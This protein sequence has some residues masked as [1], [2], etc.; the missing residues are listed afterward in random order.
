MRHQIICP[1][2]CSAGHADRIRK[3]SQRQTGITS[4]IAL[5]AKLPRNEQVF[6]CLHCSAVWFNSFDEMHHR[7]ITVVLGEYGGPNSANAFLPEAWLQKA[8]MNLT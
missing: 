3:L 7:D 6:T 8:I 5:A 2:K 4:R 1:K